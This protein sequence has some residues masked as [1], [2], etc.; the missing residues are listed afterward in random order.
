MNDLNVKYKVQKFIVSVSIILLLCKILAY[1]ITNSVGILT[2]AL[3]SIVNVVA[4]LLSLVSISVSIKPKDD[5]H[6]F[7]HGKVELLSASVEGMLI[8]VAGFIIIYEAVY[9]LFVPS[10]I[11]K[12]DIGIIIIA[13]AGLVNYIVGGYSIKVGKKYNSIALIAGGKHLQSDTYSTIGLVVGLIILYFSKLQWLDS[14]IAIVFGSIIAITGIK[15]LRNTVANL[16]D[17]ADALLLDEFLEIINSNKQVDW[18]DIKNTRIL[19]YGDTYHIDCDLIVPWYYNINQATELTEK[20]KKILNDNF[21]ENIDL[22]VHIFPCKPEN[23]K[24]CV[25]SDCKHR[26][27]PFEEKIHWT[28]KQIIRFK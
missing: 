1:Q 11:Q 20:M 2:D 17:E 9:R 16:M 8:A 25:L 13:I 5:N 19:K 3:E 22:A 21:K 26:V 18:I 7:G 12:L 24:N 4:G 14:V 23:C 10:E 15:I 28:I 6:P 27:Y